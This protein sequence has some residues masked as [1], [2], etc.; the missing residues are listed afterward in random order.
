LSVAAIPAVT[1]NI[2]SAHHPYHP[3]PA[4]RLPHRRFGEWNSLPHLSS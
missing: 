3:D 4:P 1:L 2:P